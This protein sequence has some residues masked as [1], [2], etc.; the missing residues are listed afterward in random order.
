MSGVRS[1][2]IEAPLGWW[3]ITRNKAAGDSLNI[4]PAQ[5]IAYLS[6]GAGAYRYGVVDGSHR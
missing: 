2:A 4:F 5:P 6:G 1:G 3:R